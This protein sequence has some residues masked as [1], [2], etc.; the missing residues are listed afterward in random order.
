MLEESEW[1]SLHDVVGVV[2]ASARNGGRSPETDS[3]ESDGK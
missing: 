2:L 1:R 3:D